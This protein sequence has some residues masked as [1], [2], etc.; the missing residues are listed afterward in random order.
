MKNG[1]TYDY[2]INTGKDPLEERLPFYIRQYL[3]DHGCMPDV[4]YVAHPESVPGLPDV[5][6]KPWPMPNQDIILGNEK[7]KQPI[8]IPKL[9]TSTNDSESSDLGRAGKEFL[10]PLSRRRRKKIP[11]VGETET[12]QPE[13]P[14]KPDQDKETL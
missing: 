13:V 4:C 9:Q 14:G 1:I 5:S 11:M 2:F 12:L 6:I 8:Q 7:T 3:A 10:A